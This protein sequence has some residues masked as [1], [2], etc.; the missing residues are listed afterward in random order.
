MADKLYNKNIMRLLYK[1]LSP[2]ERWWVMGQMDTFKKAFE[3]IEK[4]LLR[5]NTYI[6]NI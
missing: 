1:Y 3:N 2:A 5:I 4:D 6:I